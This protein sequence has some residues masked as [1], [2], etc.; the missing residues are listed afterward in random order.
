MGNSPSVPGPGG[1][2]LHV[3]RDDSDAGSE[4]GQRPEHSQ[5]E[6][7]DAQL[8]EIVSDEKASERIDSVSVPE[9]YVGYSNTVSNFL[10]F[11]SS[12]LMLFFVQPLSGKSAKNCRAL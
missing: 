7:T 10:N 2:R 8:A 4:R 11:T 6:N 9:F 5:I 3:K 1:G 12:L